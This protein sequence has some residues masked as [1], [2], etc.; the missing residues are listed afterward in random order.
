M[1]PKKI[2][3]IVLS[4]FLLIGCQATTEELLDSSN[5]I[6]QES[7]VQQYDGDKVELEQIKFSLPA[8]MEV[9]EETEYN[10][11]LKDGEQL[12]LLFFNPAE[13]DD[14][15]LNFVRDQQHEEEALLFETFEDKGKFAYLL[16]T[17]EEDKQFKVIIGIGG[18][19]LTTITT[20]RNLEEST[21]AMLEILNTIEYK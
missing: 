4:I 15:E 21:T 12:Y 3:L 2:G 14:S 11:L 8:N 19:K 13:A 7:F 10:V 9:Q 6:F 20:D 17:Q 5:T 16:V 18:A 1:F